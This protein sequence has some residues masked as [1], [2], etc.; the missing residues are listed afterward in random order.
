[1]ISDEATVKDKSQVLVAAKK[2][3][4]IGTVIFIYHV[5]IPG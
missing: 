5:N 1:M 2:I 3:E 4:L